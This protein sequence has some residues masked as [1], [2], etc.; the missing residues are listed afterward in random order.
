MTIGC[1]FMKKTYLLGNAQA[2]V[3]I[4]DPSGA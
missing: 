4:W 3:T 2:I 1:D